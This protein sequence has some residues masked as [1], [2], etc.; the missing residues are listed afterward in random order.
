MALGATEG[1]TVSRSLGRQ[2]RTSTSGAVG[3]RLQ[4]PSSGAKRLWLRPSR[5]A[6]LRSA[7][8]VGRP[9]DLDPIRTPA[10]RRAPGPR[11]PMRRR[12]AGGVPCGRAR[13]GRERL[14]PRVPAA[15]RGT[16]PYTFLPRSRGV[17]TDHSRSVRPRRAHRRSNGATS[18]M[19]LRRIPPANR[20]L[21]TTWSPG[22][23]LVP[24][25]GH[26]QEAGRHR[27]EVPGNVLGLDEHLAA[28]REERGEAVGPLLDVGAEGDALQHRRPSRRRSRLPRDQAPAGLRGSRCAVGL[29]IRPVAPASVAASTSAS[30][31]GHGGRRGC[32]S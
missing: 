22:R 17:A 2:L 14:A 4:P 9:D 18:V 5:I 11:R 25:V 23:V 30:C 20:S 10:L 12:H 29:T 28:G 26:R 24:N 19:L 31:R 13:S 27:A 15:N 21:S 8:R 7:R 32:R 1:A 16:G 6:P 3:R